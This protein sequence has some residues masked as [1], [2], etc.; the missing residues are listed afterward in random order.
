MLTA[1]VSG[2]QIAS[3]SARLQLLRQT[4]HADQLEMFPHMTL[5][6]ILVP[7]CTGIQ[8]NSKSSHNFCHSNGIPCVE[9]MECVSLLRLPLRVPSLL[10]CSIAVTCAPGDIY[11]SSFSHAVIPWR[12]QRCSAL[13]QWQHF[14]FWEFCNLVLLLSPFP[15]PLL[16]SP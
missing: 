4:Q 12:C 9:V 3:S 5:S 10:S 2:H 6:V 1:S 11:A 13:S 16:R 15:F 14:P 8:R 7:P